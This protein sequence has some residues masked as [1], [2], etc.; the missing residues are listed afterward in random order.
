MKTNRDGV[1]DWCQLRMPLADDD[2]STAH[3]VVNDEDLLLLA[4]VPRSHSS[5]AA[6]DTEAETEAELDSGYSKSNSPT[7]SAALG[8][9]RC[10]FNQHMY[11]M[12]TRACLII[13]D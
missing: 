11:S 4:S 2:V 3:L 10:V 6:A 9:V 7:H 1:I 13:L 5:A 8:S 12:C